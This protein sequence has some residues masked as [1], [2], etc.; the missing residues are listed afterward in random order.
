MSRLIRVPSLA[1]CLCLFFGVCSPGTGAAASR[2]GPGKSDRAR[3]APRD[4]SGL[5]WILDVLQRRITG[6]CSGDH[7]FQAVARDG[8]VT[9]GQAGDIT[10]VRAGNGLSGGGDSGDVTLDVSAPLWLTFAGADPV[11]TLRATGTGPGIAV[12]TSGDGS[13]VVSSTPGGT[14]VRGSTRSIATAAVRGDNTAGEAIVGV[15]AGGAGVGAVVGRNDGSGPGVRGFTMGT[16]AGVLGQGGVAG[17]SGPGVRGE[18]AAAGDTAPAVEAVTRG[19]GPALQATS[20]SAARLAGRFDGNV[21]IAGDLTVTGVK[22]GF[23]IDDP[24]DPQGKTLAHTPVESDGYQVTYSGNVRT[25]ARGLAT[26]RLPRYAQAVASGWR[27]GLTTIG[28][29]ARAIVAR[30]VAGNRFVVR[31]DRPRVKVSW[32]VIGTRRDAY[33]KAH[34]FAAE[35]PKPPDQRGV[36][37]HPAEVGASGGSQPEAP[38]ARSARKTPLASD[39]SADGRPRRR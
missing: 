20:T 37:L 10:A 25:D 8:S 18:I 24:L 38:S 28:T 36:Y 4:L 31:T 21:L 13:G 3:G 12:S 34:P 30:E 17:G 2:P 29:F 11:M 27:Y 7:F 14:A 35:R 32:I 22:T 1:V 26:V 6:T 39:R 33:A 16:G 15:T 9:C 5:K 19:D 23:L